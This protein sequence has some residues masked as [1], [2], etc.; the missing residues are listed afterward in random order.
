MFRVI[1]LSR[2]SDRVKLHTLMVNV[3]ACLRKGDGLSALS[4]TGNKT[5]D[6]E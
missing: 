2:Q 3:E 6:D 4:R 1:V 5:Y